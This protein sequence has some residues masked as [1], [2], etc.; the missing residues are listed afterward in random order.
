MSRKRRFVRRPAGSTTPHT[1]T[2]GTPPDRGFIDPAA[3]PLPAK[4]IWWGVGRTEVSIQSLP[5]ERYKV[6]ILSEPIGSAEREMPSQ[7]PHCLTRVLDTLAEAQRAFEF[8]LA[9]TVD[10]IRESL[11]SMGRADTPVIMTDGIRAPQGMTWR[12]QGKSNRRGG[13]G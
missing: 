7:E 10:G 3:V 6:V 9:G 8:A 11:A 2:P 5:D 12:D 1:D 4:I 13:R